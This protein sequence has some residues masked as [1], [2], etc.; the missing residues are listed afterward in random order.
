MSSKRVNYSKMIPKAHIDF[1]VDRYNVG[2]RDETIAEDVRKRATKMKWPA[3]AITAAEKYAVERHHKNIGTYNAVMGGRLRNPSVG[4]AGRIGPVSAGVGAGARRG[5]VGVG[6][7]VGLGRHSLRAGIGVGARRNPG[8]QVVLSRAL[9]ERLSQWH[10]GMDE[11]YALSS[12]AYNG[13]R[14]PIRPV[15]LDMIDKALTVLRRNETSLESTV[16]GFRRMA[17]F[18]EKKRWISQNMKNLGHL[19]RTITQLQAARDRAR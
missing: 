15:S 5:T 17:N 14:E 6:A 10:N 16:E 19:R 1:L 3:G 7:R 9:V 8:K 12:N 11:V 2:A 13:E 4:G 18:S